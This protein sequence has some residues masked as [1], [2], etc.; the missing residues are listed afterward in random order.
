MDEAL[1]KIFRACANQ[2]AANHDAVLDRSDP[3][4]EHQFRVSLRR[5]R[6]ALVVFKT[7]LPAEDAA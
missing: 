2:C 7:V 3:E 5:M 1:G 6:S 4:G